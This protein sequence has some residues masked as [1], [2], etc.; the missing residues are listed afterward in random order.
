MA[1][2]GATVRTPVTVLDFEKAEFSMLVGKVSCLNKPISSVSVLGPAIQV[3]FGFC[4]NLF[5]IFT[6]PVS[7]ALSSSC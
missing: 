6:N 3:I 4:A 1:Q 7:L 2:S 5:F